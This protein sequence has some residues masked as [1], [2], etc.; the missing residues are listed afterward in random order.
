[1]GR[2]R[3]ARILVVATLLSGLAGIVA[4]ASPSVRVQFEDGKLTLSARAAAAPDV[5]KAVAEKTGVRFVVDSEIKPAPITIELEAMPLERAI[6]NLIVAVP[7]AAGHT[8]TYGR[9]R[10]GTPQLVEVTLFGPGKAPG[11]GS[12]TVYAAS[13]QSVAP[14][15]LPTPDLEERMDKMVQAG[16]PRETAER[17]IAL[18]REV[19]KLQATPAPGSYRP[20][21]LSPAMREQLQ[22]LIDRGVPMEEGSIEDPRGAAPRLG[23]SATGPLTGWVKGTRQA[24]DKRSSGECHTAARWRPP[25]RRSGS[26]PPQHRA[27]DLSRTACSPCRRREAPQTTFRTRS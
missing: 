23:H 9:G 19:Q 8:M 20:E 26:S 27:R 11:E 3:S 25:S 10:R 22:P 5:F 6:R 18:T 21:D 13:G 15:V 12:S 17:V 1:V 14:G 2:F 4:A 16:V 24:R 7:Q